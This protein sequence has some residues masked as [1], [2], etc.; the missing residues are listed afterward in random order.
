MWG[1]NIN[2]EESTRMF[3]TFWMEFDDPQSG[4]PLY[5]RLLQEALDEG[6]TNINL[7]CRFL[8]R[9][10]PKLYQQLV[11]YPQEMIPIFD[12]VI[13]AMKMAMPGNDDIKDRMQ[14]RPFNMLE[15]RNMR[16]LNPADIDTLISIKG[17]VIRAGSVIPDMKVAHFECLLCH[18][19]LQVEIDDGVIAEPNVCENCSARKTMQLIHNRGKYG[20][21]QSVKVQETPDAI[22][23]GETP[24]TVTVY[25]YDNLVDVVKPGDRV[26]ISGIYRAQPVRVNPRKRTVRTVFRTYVDSIHVKKADKNRLSAEDSKATEGSEYYTS[27]EE[28]DQL[29]SVVKEREEA[30]KVL[31]ADPEIYRRLTEALAPSVYEMDD[32]KK[33]I[34]CMLFGGANEEG[35]GHGRFRG[36][37]NVLLCGDPGTGKSQLLQYVHKIAPRGIYTS[38]KGSSAVGLTASISKDPE[39]GEHLL[40]SGALV[41]SDRGVCC[42]D[43]FD[44]MSDSTRSILHEVMEQQ[45]VSIAKAGIVCTL[46][47]RTSILASANP[48]ESRYNPNLSVVKNIQLGPTLLSRFDLIYLVLDQPNEPQDRR[49]AM[50]I[51]ALY[52]K[53]PPKM[54]KNFIPVEQLTAYIS[55]A[56]QR[57]QP[58]LTDEAADALIR[59]YVDM[60]KLGQNAQRKVVTA[61]PRQLE[62]MIRLAEALARMHFSEIVTEENVIEARRLMNVATQ[63]AA[64]DPKTGKIDMDLLTTGHSAAER[65][66][67]ELQ[68][69]G[70]RSF[71]EQK[72]GGMRLKTLMTAFNETIGQSLKLTQDE[73]RA[74][75]RSME[76]GEIVTIQKGFVRLT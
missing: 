59:N 57:V 53:N 23:E 60:R 69:D 10:N 33:G 19:S 67:M 36:E 55:Y 43:E 4:A 52:F 6:I 38:G 29:N 66:A 62:S 35:A 12:L 44:K 48:K 31:A 65:Q 61:T 76:D 14:V 2:V 17:M 26:E 73:F 68:A 11:R 56:R 63:T 46:N 13:D 16:E 27:F 54:K 64:T 74:V 42:I 75:L 58:K 70:L 18:F 72:G 39:T 41:L 47:A 49:L 28:S 51:V 1:T 8:Q 7:N 21:K 20:D 25:T 37:L 9:F 3:E 40:E 34:L 22:P 30:L 71:L 24:H 50:H 5:P 15:S 45:T 32:V